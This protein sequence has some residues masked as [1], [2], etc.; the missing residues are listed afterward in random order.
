MKKTGVY[1]LKD[2]NIK[3]I[4]GGERQRVLISRA[5]CQ[6]APVMLLD[7]PSSSLDIYHELNVMDI[8]RDIV[9]EKGS[10]VICVMHDLNTAARYADFLFLLSNGSIVS[11]G[12]ANEVFKSENLE[13]VYSV[14]SEFV[15]IDGAKYILVKD[16]I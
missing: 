15:E 7:E 1:H 8:L 13:S 5:L 10:T 11:K 14:K 4:S 2:K 12:K 6:D 16:T 3:E 9:K